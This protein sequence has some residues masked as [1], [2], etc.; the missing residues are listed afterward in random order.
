MRLCRNNECTCAEGKQKDD[1]WLSDNQPIQFQFVSQIHQKAFVKGG[2]G[3]SVSHIQADKL[4]L[5]PV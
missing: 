4:D 1:G 5:L 2:G 3:I